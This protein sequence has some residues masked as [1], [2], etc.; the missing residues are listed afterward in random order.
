[1]KISTQS[2]YGLRALV[3]LAAHGDSQVKDISLRQSVSPR[4][5][6]QIFQKLKRAGIVKSTRGPLGG[7]HLAKMPQ[8]ITV[9][10]EV[11][12]T[13]GGDI[14]LVHCYGTK[15]SHNRTPCSRM[16]GCLVKDMWTKAS[17]TLMVYLDS[18]TLN[19]LCQDTMKKGPTS[20]GPEIDHL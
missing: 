8:E 9:G 18:V 15:M 17:N 5:I 6:E 2:R 16:E 12:A 1:M 13:E 3:D 20:L 19:D 10:D 7:Y 14:E 4:Y 11:R